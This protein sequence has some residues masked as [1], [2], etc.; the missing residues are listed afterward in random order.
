[1]PGGTHGRDIVK[2]MTLRLLYRPEVRDNLHRLHD[3]LS[4]QDHRGADDFSDHPHHPHNGVDL[5]KISAVG[6]QLLPDV[7][8]RVNSDHVH[9]LV[10]QEQEVVHHLIKHPKIAVIQIPLI[11]IEGGHDKVAAIVQPSEITRSGSGENLGNGLFILR[12]DRPVI[13]EEIAAHILPV[14][15]TGFPCPFMVL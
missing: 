8:Y 9:P 2:Q 7:G 13:E 12:R 15:L 11:G 14:S 1:M 6:T 3:H 5:G 10:S 4:Q